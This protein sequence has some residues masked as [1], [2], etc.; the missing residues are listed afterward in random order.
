MAKGKE[1][2]EFD[3][4]LE[5]A[6]QYAVNKIEAKYQDRQDQC[7]TFEALAK[8][9]DGSR[10]ELGRGVESIKE[11]GKDDHLYFLTEFDPHSSISSHY[12]DCIEV[13]MVRD[14]ILFDYMNGMTELNTRKPAYIIPPHSPHLIGSGRVSAV[15]MVVFKKPK[16]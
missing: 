9:P 4:T 16:V 7:I 14:G 12:H 5:R 15:A 11:P 6:R 3:L 2:Q 10:I 13:V 1:R 8:I